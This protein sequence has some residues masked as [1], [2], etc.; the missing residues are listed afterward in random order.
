VRAKRGKQ[1]GGRASRQKK[2]WKRARRRGY[3][4]NTGRPFELLAVLAL[5]LFVIG[6]VAGFTWAMDREIRGGI[7]RQ[8]VEAAQRPDWVPLQALPA[9]V[10]NAFV[11]VVD[12]AFMEA[13]ALRKG[14][15]GTTLARQLVR[16]VHLLPGTLTGEARELV[17][18]PVLEHRATKP[19]LVELFLNRVYIGQEAGYPV[20][21]IYHA[22]QEY[23]GKEPQQLTLS[24]A[25]TLAGLLLEPRIT[26]P[27]ER[28]GALGPRRNEVLR[29]ML[30]KG[31][32][33]PE[34]YQQA[35]RERL[36]FQPGIREMPMTRPP[37]WME[38]AP[39]IRLP[40]ELRPRP[41]TLEAG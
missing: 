21:G 18:G 35:I 41:D 39:V 12:P 13:R 19:A 5:G 26:N 7:L 28:I 11:A 6:G 34:E 17:M 8:K 38:E 33:T 4:E 24:E 27:Q 40:E 31:L 9:Y 3:S 23:F 20:Y 29:V 32:I 22:A 25:A 15:S 30:E 10:P 37:G 1:L 36:G 2:E 16:Q 14:E